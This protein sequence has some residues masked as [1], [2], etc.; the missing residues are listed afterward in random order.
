M[1]Y[2]SIACIIK[3][4]LHSISN[5]SISFE[6]MTLNGVDYICIHY[7]RID[8]YLSKCRY[9]KL[10]TFIL[11]RYVSIPT[12]CNTFFLC[13]F[14][15]HRK[16]VLLRCEVQQKLVLTKCFRMAFDSWKSWSTWKATNII[17]IYLHMFEYRN[18]KG[19]GKAFCNFI[20]DPMKPLICLF[21]NLMGIYF[22][23][24]WFRVL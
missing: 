16:L 14:S 13:S 8:A 3:L 17:K 15:D 19:C 9:Q 21:I 4:C 10:K 5:I 2:F 11:V 12:C 22:Y 1:K 7:S 18:R 23:L 20:F 24:K 6:Q